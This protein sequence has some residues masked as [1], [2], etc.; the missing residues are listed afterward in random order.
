MHG[1][2]PVI[3]ARI[4]IARI[5][6]VGFGGNPLRWRAPTVSVDGDDVELVIGVRQQVLHR[7]RRGP[8]VTVDGNDAPRVVETLILH[9]VVNVLPGNLLPR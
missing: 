9:L 1:A 8:E 3:S 2:S 5:N 7:R 4:G 6:D